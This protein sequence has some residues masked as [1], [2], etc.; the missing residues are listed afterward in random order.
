[1]GTDHES[2]PQD[3][4][5][6]GHHVQHLG[7]QGRGLGIQHF[8]PDCHYGGGG[9]GGVLDHPCLAPTSS[10]YYSRFLFTP[11]MSHHSH[12]PSKLRA[13]AEKNIRVSWSD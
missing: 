2:L 11:P 13:A 8:F 3:A 7:A 5:R 9:V 10:L 4:G 12:T 1:M 6:R